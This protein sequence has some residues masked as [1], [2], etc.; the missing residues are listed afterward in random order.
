MNMSM[1]NKLALSLGALTL[2]AVLAS[3]CIDMSYGDGY[4]T[5]PLGTGTESPAIIETAPPETTA[6]TLEITKT[7]ET[8]A[9]PDDTGE[10]TTAAPDVTAAPETT[11]E[12]TAPPP[13][14]V[15][16]EFDVL[17]KITD[18]GTTGGKKCTATLRYPALTGLE[19]KAKQS[20]INELLFDIASG[21]YQNRL[22]NASD[23]I[24]AGT[25]VS[26]EITET[27]VTYLGG[28]LLSVRS[29]GR[30]D[31]ADDTAD[32][33]FV[34]CNNISLSKGRDIKL[35]NTYSDFGIVMDLFKSGKFKQISGDPALISD[36][37]HEQ[38][39]EQYKLFAQ[40]GT[41]PE[42][43]FTADSLVLV[44][45]TNREHGFFAEFSIAIPS[46]N[47]CLLI[48]PIK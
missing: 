31:Y 40:Y 1:K 37:T 18:L 39:M 2:T 16:Y 48:S 7:P 5:M 34:Y 9:A 27:S 29:V 3:S 24:S 10:V 6:E 4:R 33:E 28:D 36:L 12:D 14:I 32:E 35:K 17:E 46:V 8:T 45:E 20:K 30:I 25:A 41:F 42:T 44:I 15:T 26:Y 21:E 47:D 43:Y 11:A 13:V 38:L 23:I 19:D 22:P